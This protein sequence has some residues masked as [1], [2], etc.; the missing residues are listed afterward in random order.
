MRNLH[1]FTDRQIRLLE[2]VRKRIYD[3]NDPDPDIITHESYEW[4]IEQTRQ[5]GKIPKI[6]FTPYTC[7]IK[8][9]LVHQAG[10]INDSNQRKI[11]E[12]RH[13]YGIREARNRESRLF[14]S[15]WNNIM[16]KVK[17]ATFIAGLMNSLFS[18]RNQPLSVLMHLMQAIVMEEYGPQIKP[19]QPPMFDR[20]EP[21]PAESP[22]SE[23][24]K[25]YDRQL[26][27]LE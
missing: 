14:D 17:K 13:Q 18:T 25:A 15:E 11:A 24:I 12:I 3:I 4:S 6:T 8:A 1:P 5:F 21:R 10:L 7:Q 9:E 20:R 2:S 19:Q 26:A 16:L 23:G 22:E 27:D